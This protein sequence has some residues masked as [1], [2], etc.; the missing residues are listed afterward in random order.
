MYKSWCIQLRG[1][2]RGE[3]LAG[4]K[5]Y[6]QQRAGRTLSLNEYYIFRITRLTVIKKD[7]RKITPGLSEIPLSI[8]V[9]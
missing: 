3:G 6:F 7:Y 8:F 9:I 5:E 1:L 2:G 4:W